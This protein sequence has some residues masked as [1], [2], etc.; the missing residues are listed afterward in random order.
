MGLYGHRWLTLA[1]LYKVHQIEENRKHREPLVSLIKVNLSRCYRARPLLARFS[2]C[3]MVGLH[4]QYFLS[5]NPESAVR[6]ELFL[7]LTIKAH[8]AL[9]SYITHICNCYLMNCQLLIETKG[10]DHD[11][12]AS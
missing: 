9:W 5:D 2:L 3:S 8:V 12:T 10:Q 4:G 7:S 11:I 6:R 1:L